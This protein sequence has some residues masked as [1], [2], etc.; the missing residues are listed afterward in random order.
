MKNSK[1][2]QVYII[3]RTFHWFIVGMIIPVI[4]MVLLDKGLDLLQVG[5]LF[6]IQSTTVI[7]FELPSGGLSDAIGRKKVYIISLVAMLIGAILFMFSTEFI[8][9]VLVSIINGFAQSLSSGT[10]D[11]WFVDEFNKQYPEGNLQKMLAKSHIFILVSLAISSLIAGILPM[12]LG[13]FIYSTTGLS[14]YSGNFIVQVLLIIVHL[15]LTIGI[16]EE[17]IY[18]S[19]KKNILEGF[20]VLPSILKSSIEEGV[21]NKCIFL[22]LLTAVAWGIGFSG[23]EAFWQPKVN[24]ILGEESKDW[25]LGILNAGYFFAGA[26]GSMVV[27]HISTFF[28]DN[29][30]KILVI[31]RTILGSLFIILAFQE[32]IVGFSICYLVL[33]SING[34][35]DSPYYTLFNNEAREQNRATL[36]SLESLFMKSGGVIGAIVIGYISRKYSISLG[37]SLSGI[38][39]IISSLAFFMLD[40]LQRKNKSIEIV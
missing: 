18:I 38:V 35:S 5:L 24:D 34:M 2:A 4:T 22:L 20:K 28:S 33:Y 13:Q 9:I 31:L 32:S 29:L 23:L 36:L 30:A 14:I 25:I 1:I 3:N 15:I 16:V 21:K 26:I 10:I 12:T 19:R 27:T 37:W 17:R 40:K 8:L 7:I 39:L 6:S 11:A